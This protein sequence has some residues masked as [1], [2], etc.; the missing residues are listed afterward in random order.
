VKLVVAEEDNALFLAAGA[1]GS[2][3]IYTEHL[4]LIH[5]IRK[6]LLRTAS[7]LD[8][9]IIKHTSAP[10]RRRMAVVLLTHAAAS[11]SASARRRTGSDAGAG[12]RLNSPPDAAEIKNRRCRAATAAQVDG[13]RRRRRRRSSD[14]WLARSGRRS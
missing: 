11:A 1:R 2:A 13:R 5:L 8:Y 4:T 9:I 3:A 6:V 7:Y 14:N 12:L 10:L